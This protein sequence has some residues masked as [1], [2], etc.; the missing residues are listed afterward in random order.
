MIIRVQYPTPLI[1]SL[2]SAGYA[3]IDYLCTECINHP[4]C[5]MEYLPL[6]GVLAG[7]WTTFET[8]EEAI[9]LLRHRPRT[10]HYFDMIVYCYQ[11][12]NLRYGRICNYTMNKHS[13]HR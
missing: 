13:I 5:I 3:D 11:S 1:Q 7:T 2:L 9:G 12:M 10:V 8:G 4:M 6:Y